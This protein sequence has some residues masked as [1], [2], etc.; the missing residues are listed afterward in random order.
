MIKWLICAGLLFASSAWGVV[1]H[2]VDTTLPLKCSFSGTQ[3]NRILVNGGFVSKVIFPESYFTVRLEEESGQV[4]VTSLGGAFPKPM[5]I[6]VITGTGHVQDIEVTFEN[7]ETEVVVLHEPKE[8]FEAELLEISSP[9]SKSIKSIKTILLGESPVGYVRLDKTQE[10]KFL[11]EG[12]VKV[13][14]IS[15]FQGA[16]EVIQSFRLTNESKCDLELIES[17]LKEF[18][19]KWIF[20]TKNELSPGESI[21]AVVARNTD[22]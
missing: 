17:E 13:E 19:D 16:Y 11:K 3:H 1:V 8:G 9:E 2:R 7:K 10:E 22:G 5:T 20:L 14:S 15:F 4:F 21:I 6:S 18:G 12:M